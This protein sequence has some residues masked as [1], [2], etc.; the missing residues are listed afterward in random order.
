MNK[1]VYLSSIRNFIS[2]AIKFI[3]ASVEKPS[4]LLRRQKITKKHIFNYLV[5]KEI[6]VLAEWQKP[7]LIQKSLELWNS[8]ESIKVCSY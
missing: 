7:I 4:D 8:T 5:K 1:A 3:L 6:V 2:E